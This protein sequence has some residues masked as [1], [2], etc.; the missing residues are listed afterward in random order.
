MIQHVSVEVR[1]DDVPA[2]LA[3]WALLGFEPV[4]APPA[5]AAVSTWVQAGP[6]QVHLLHAR[7][8]VVPPE[9]HVAVVVENYEAT[10]AALREDGFDPIPRSEHWGSPRAFVRCPAGHRVE[11]MAFAPA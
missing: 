2:C 7:E 9:G 3:F 5:L 8:P 4:D 10:L 1:E 6:T 11:L